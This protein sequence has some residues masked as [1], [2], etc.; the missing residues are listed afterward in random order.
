[1][2][3]DFDN[4]STIFYAL[5]VIREFE[6]RESATYVPSRTVDFCFFTWQQKI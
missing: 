3:Q 4:R 5:C 6:I 2:Q 1:L